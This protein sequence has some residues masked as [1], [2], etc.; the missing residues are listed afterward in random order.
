M[1][2][3][4]HAHIIPKEVIG[5]LG[6]LGPEIVASTSGAS[7][8]RIGESKV[9]PLPEGAYSLKHRIRYLD[10]KNIDVQSISVTH[11]LFLYRMSVKEAKKIARIQNDGIAK[12]VREYP[13]RLIGNATLPLQDIDESLQELERVVHDSEIRGIE[14]G[15]NIGGKNLDDKALW[16]FYEKAQDYDLPIFVHPN[17]ILAPERMRRYYSPIVLGTLMETPLAISS[18]RFGGV[19]ENFPKLKFLFSHGGGIMPYQIGRLQKGLE[20]RSECREVINKPIDKYFQKMYFDTILFHKQALE[21]LISFVGADKLMMGTDY[22][23]NMGD[24]DP[25]KTL[26]NVET[27][28]KNDRQKIQGDNAAKL[29]KI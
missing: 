25:L 21:F 13:D 16:P 8:L 23:F 11:H 15:T 12:A 3:D 20:V 24:P 22:P 19:L 5:Q 10:E 29:F 9:G 18:I 1:N 7:L 26:S 2:V 6:D 27:L 14:I 4:V 17:D 28:S